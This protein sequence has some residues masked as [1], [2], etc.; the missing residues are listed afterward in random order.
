MSEEPIAFYFDA[1]VQVVIAKQLKHDGIEAVTARD[2]KKLRDDDPSHLQR[3][4][5]QN[6]VLV[7]Y[8]DDFVKM[9]QQGV[10]HTGIVFVPTR[11]RNIGIVV[12]ELRIFQA[13]YT[14]NDVT[15]LVWYLTDTSSK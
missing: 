3:A 15:N 10:E 14:Q 5:E 12:K 1:C 7:T 8:D 6:R 4:I 2:L 13:R 11:Y 9:A